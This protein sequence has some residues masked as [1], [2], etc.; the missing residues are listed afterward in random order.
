MFA[1]NPIRAR[2]TGALLCAAAL[3]GVTGCTATVT[4]RPA[5]AQVI[6][7]NPVVY[8]DDAPDGIYDRP[9]VYY[10]GRPAYLVGT[11]WYYPSEGGWVYFRDEPVELR[12]ART[13]RAFVRVESDAPRRTSV[14]QRPVRRRYVEQPTETRRR[15]YD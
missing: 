10:H 6:Y 9:S 13:T 8:V 12:R 15:R 1:T 7:D 4:A 14:E 11:R 2:L 3:A 5:R